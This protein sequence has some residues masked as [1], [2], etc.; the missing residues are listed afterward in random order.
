M[1]D[2]MIGRYYLQP[3]VFWSDNSIRNSL[4]GELRAG[5]FGDVVPT[6]RRML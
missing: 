2:D 6:T 5:G 4:E 1:K 3:T